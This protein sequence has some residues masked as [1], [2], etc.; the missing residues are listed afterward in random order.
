MSESRNDRGPR[1]RTSINMNEAFEVRYWSKEFNVSVAQ[2]K[3]LVEK[4]I[5]RLEKRTIDRIR[6]APRDVVID[7]ARRIWPVDNGNFGGL[8]HGKNGG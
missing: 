5:V 6:Y 4:E 8:R 7:F 2:L 3:A 1:D